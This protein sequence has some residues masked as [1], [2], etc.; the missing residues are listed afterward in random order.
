MEDQERISNGYSNS[1]PLNP[2]EVRARGIEVY[3]FICDV[4]FL[5]PSVIPRRHN[6]M[7]ALKNTCFGEKQSFEKRRVKDTI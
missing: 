5:L 4:D 3:T 6:W 2:D 7:H 1:L